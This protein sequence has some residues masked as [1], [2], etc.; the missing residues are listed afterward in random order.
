MVL[1]IVTGVL[2]FLNFYGWTNGAITGALQ[3]VS[4]IV[5]AVLL[6]ATVFAAARYQGVRRRKL[7]PMAPYKIFTLPFA[8]I[9]V[10]ALGNACVLVVL[11]L[12]L[13]GIISSL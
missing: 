6:A 1:A 10:S 11:T 5:Q 8:V 12:R 9:L 3:I 4:I 7:Y 2:A 13:S